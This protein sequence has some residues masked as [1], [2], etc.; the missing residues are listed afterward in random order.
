MAL[1]GHIV[2]QE[3][4]EKL[5]KVNLGKKLP[6]EVIEKMRNS[7]KGRIHS[8]EARRKSS[9][10]R[11]R[12]GLVPPSRKGKKHSQKSIEKMKKAH[13]GFKH[14]IETRKK[15]SIDLMGENSP[16][17]QG[18]ITEIN[19]KIRQ[20]L[21][22]RLWREAVFARD[23]YTC[24]WCG[25][26]KGGNLN[27]DHIKPFALFPELRFAIDNGRTLCEP[28]HKTT[29]TWGSKTRTKRLS[30]PLLKM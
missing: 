6:K 12:L 17:W 24:I 28:C 8:P 18:G 16:N 10:T 3:T 22:Y 15:M 30:T 13:E 21:E 1:K 4:R 29:D 2:T 26:N 7:M 27:A 25:D 14:S 5:R 11:K 23:N 20:S 9:E 19:I